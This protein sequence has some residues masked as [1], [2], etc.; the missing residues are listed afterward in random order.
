MN[1]PAYLRRKVRELLAMT[2]GYW[3]TDEMI[4]DKM[5]ELIEPNA[6]AGDVRI[7]VEWNLA[8]SYF[9]TRVNEDSEEAEWC[10]T[11]NGIAKNQMS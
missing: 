6:P 9:N 1:K 3:L 4:I 11:K 5:N 8:R 10:I 7:A 2:P